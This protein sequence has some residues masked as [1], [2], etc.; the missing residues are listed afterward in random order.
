MRFIRSSGTVEHWSSARSTSE[1]DP[2]L[3]LTEVVEVPPTAQYYSH[4]P[5][6]LVVLPLASSL[7]WW[8]A[9]VVTG[10]I[11]SGNP[12]L[13]ATL[14]PT[15]ASAGQRASRPW[16][17]PN[18]ILWCAPAGL[19]PQESR[20]VGLRTDA[21]LSGAST[22]RTYLSGAGKMCQCNRPVSEPHPDS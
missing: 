10:E 21:H 17:F 8:G 2:W 19:L 9:A 20:M 6:S 3:R 7:R 22:P 1:R 18:N 15:R 14:W 16:C 11:A 13:P 12:V 4:L 5:S